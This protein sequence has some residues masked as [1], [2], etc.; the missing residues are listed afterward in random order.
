MDTIIDGTN[1]TATL[2][3]KTRQVVL[4]LLFSHNDESFYLRQI[5][6][7]TGAGLGP[8]Q[9]ELKN[10]TESG[11]IIREARGRQVYY[12]ANAKCPIFDDLKSIVSKTFGMAYII[13]QSL[14]IALDEIRVAFIFGSIASG[15]EDKMSDIDVMVIGNISFGDTVNLL[16]S[17]EEKLAREINAV[18]YPIA[19][20][21]QKLKEGHHFVR[22]VMDSQKIFITG[23]QDELERLAE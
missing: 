11:V 23:D 8:V 12:R 15:N 21:R 10:L 9:R 22:N 1:L 14:S 16:S 5:V 20:F 17:A 2:F 13:R 4:A 19:E 18:V 3:G 6:R 7:A